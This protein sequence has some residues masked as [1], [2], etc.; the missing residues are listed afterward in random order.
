MKTPMICLG[1]FALTI[2]SCKREQQEIKT[3]KVAKTPATSASPAQDPHAGMPGMMPGGVIPEGGTAGAPGMGGG[4]PHAGV[5]GMGADPHSGLGAAPARKITDD[6]PTHWEKGPS[7]GMRAAS[8]RLIGEGGEKAVITLSSLRSAPSSKINATNMWREQLGQASVDDAAI[9]QLPPVKTSL[10]DGVLVD[11]TSAKP[12]DVT[13]KPERLIGAIVENAGTAWY[14]KLVGDAALV[15]A[16]RNA[17]LQWMPT[18]KASDPEPEKIPMHGI[19]PGDA[20][21]AASPPPAS[22]GDGSVT[23]TLP[24]GW[25]LANG[26]SGRYATI[27]VSGVDGAKGELAIFHF[28]GDVGGDLANVNRWRSQ[29]GLAP[30]ADA[31]LAASITKVAAGP[32][33]IQVMDATGVQTRCTAGWVKHGGET[34][35]FKFTGPDAL[36]GAEKARFTAFLESVRFTKPE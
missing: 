2:V 20:A 6:A 22:A 10:G 7:S 5:P 1:A 28:P 21:A 3:Y 15:A 12:N 27:A 18:V 17:F 33:T 35:F 24:E 4:D 23:W 19:K 13:G 25:A 34:W 14:F 30:I 8:Y 16:E 11:V 26:S 9:Q 29:I 31:E 32:K 36:V